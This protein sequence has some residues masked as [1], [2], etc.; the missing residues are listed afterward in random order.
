MNAM[1]QARRVIE[2][3]QYDGSCTI[4]EH[5]KVRDGKTKLIRY[6][7]VIVWNDQPCHLVFK[8]T[9]SA[10]QSGAATAICQTVELIISPDIEIK[11][12]SKITVRQ[13]GVT[14]DYTRSGVPAVYATHQEIILEL[15]KG[16]A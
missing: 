16:W 4:T 3:Y 15:F 11:A 1:S 10:G 13:H 9:S 8:N 2:Q 12:G 7:D 6:E 5:R 14:T